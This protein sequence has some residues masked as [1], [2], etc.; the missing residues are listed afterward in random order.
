MIS[1]RPASLLVAG[2]Y[3]GKSIVISQP[4]AVA[5]PL[6][7]FHMRASTASRSSTRAVRSVPRITA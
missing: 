3:W 7:T 1:I 2:A 5:T 4:V 6:M